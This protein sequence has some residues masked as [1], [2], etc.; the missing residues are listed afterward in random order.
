MAVTPQKP[1]D[2][3]AV[4]GKVSL[5]HKEQASEARAAAWART[6]EK[7]RGRQMAPKAQAVPIRTTGR[8]FDRVWYGHCLDQAPNPVAPGSE[9]IRA[10]EAR[11]YR[12]TVKVHHPDHWRPQ[13]QRP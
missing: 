8:E 7:L 10:T 12:M 11:C 13:S 5:T 2:W 3:R 9:R 6:M 4:V 1:I